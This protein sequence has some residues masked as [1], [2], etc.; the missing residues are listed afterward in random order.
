MKRYILLTSLAVALSAG[1][2]PTDNRISTV[3]ESGRQ[4]TV[5]AVTPYIIKVTNAP[6]GTNLPD[7]RML[8]PVNDTDFAATAST[9]GKISV[10]TVGLPGGG[11][12]VATLVNRSGAV[13][14]S[15]PGNISI[16][17]TGVRQ[18]TDSTQSL[19]LIVPPGGRWL[20]GG[21]RGNSL[22]LSGDTL[23]MYNR[24]TYG[25]GAGDPRIVQMNITMP[26]VMSSN[27]YALVFDDYA[28]A[29]LILGNE[30]E[31]I[32]ESQVPVTYYVISGPAENPGEAPSMAGVQ[33]ALSEIIGTQPIAPLW[34]LGYI[35]SKYGY[36]TSDE[37]IGTVDRLKAEGYPLDGIVLDLY[38]YGK[39]QD[40]GRLDWEPEQW[41]DPKGML[42]DLRS[43]NVNLLSISQPYVLRN[44]K[45]ID[46]Y[47]FLADNNMLVP[48]SAGRPG[49]VKIWVG[50]G[51]MLD[52]SNPATRSWL[53]DLY[54]S[55]RKDGV[56]GM[57]GDLGEP[58][59]HP[60]SLVHYNGLP[61]RLYHNLYGNDWASIITEMMARDYP[62]ER[63]M[64]L[65]RGGTI[66]L[67]RESVFPWSGDVARSWEG[68][69]AQLP[70]M[71]NSAVSGLGYMSHD[72]GG[73]AVDPAAPTDPELYVRWLQLGLF[74]P[75]LRTHA[76]E[77]AEPYNY[78]EQRDIVLPLIKER[79]RW[80]PNNYSMSISNALYG[81]PMV[82]TL[83]YYYPELK[84]AAGKITDQYL[85]GGDVMVAPVLEKGATSRKVT[86]PGELR[87]YDLN[88]P[89][90][91][92]RD[93]TVVYPAP[94]AVLPHF[95]KEGTMIPMA[96]YPMQSTAD[97][98]NDTFT[99]NLFPVAE[100]DFISYIM[101]DD[102]TTPSTSPDYTLYSV[103][104]RCT[105]DADNV[106]I[107]M[108]QYSEATTGRPYHLTFKVHDIDRKP[109]AV[110]D[111]AG[112]K[113]KFTYDKATRSV[114]FTCDYTPGPT[115]V[116][117]TINR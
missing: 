38:W 40:M 33:M 65:M 56:A 114:T 45:G 110:R 64:T 101:T 113:L 10:L 6:V 94:L 74:T 53:A 42:A 78:P 117:Y 13:G 9:P 26:L 61:A 79:Y 86:F 106:K 54:S 109:K 89:S 66:G 15:M 69:Q 95:V 11:E 4:V 5:S 37:T 75:T 14:I 81:I 99:L 68:M 27:G 1:A 52:V 36:K 3:T 34:T 41:P 97:Y 35:T 7:S 84:E 46:N 111:A 16:A 12:T 32:T 17:D 47:R 63:Y 83:D 24:P 70:I 98:R 19:S 57:W 20:G 93:T 21:E 8:L 100:G 55:M 67:Q 23:V 103:A 90:V 50:E 80:L 22:D 105:S 112:K 92:Y 71:I 18:L 2:A 102:T 116:T 58:E 104:L 72:V 62:D 77:M 39:E 25:Y 108:V 31:Y 87:W 96:D 85:W 82:T 51:G 76:Q 60:D 91:T 29:E 44:G 107:D 59:M 73:F 115:P 43:K 28:A 30:V 88:N 48:D 49:E